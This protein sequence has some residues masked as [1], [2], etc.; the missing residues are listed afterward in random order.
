M[1]NK[2]VDL[3]NLHSDDKLF[4][5]KLPIKSIGLFKYPNNCSHLSGVIGYIK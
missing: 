1:A 5:V 4:H 3:F 2:Y